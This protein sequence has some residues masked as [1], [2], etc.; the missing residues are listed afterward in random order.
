M[1]LDA[2]SPQ[3]ADSDPWSVSFTKTTQGQQSI[4]RLLPSLIPPL[5]PRSLVPFVPPLGFC[6]PQVPVTGDTVASDLCMHED[7]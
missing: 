2:L 1:S 6:S 4:P 7:G 3:G 5:G